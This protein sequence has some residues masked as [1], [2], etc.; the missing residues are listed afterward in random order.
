MANWLDTALYPFDRAVLGA[1]HSFA[2]ASGGIL[3]WLMKLLGLVGEGGAC[4]IL[5]GLILCL[6]KKTRKQGVCVLFALACGAIITNICL[7]NIVARPRPFADT[8]KPFYDWWVYIGS[9]H[10]SKNSFPSGH[11]TA[12]MASMLGAFLCSKKRKFAWGYF[13]IALLMGFSR[14]YLVVHYATDVLAGLLAGALGGLSAF[15]LVRW[16]FSA[17]EQNRHKRAIAAFLDFDLPRLFSK[18]KEGGNAPQ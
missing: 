8:L 14:M 9:P 11:T 4:F 3:D 10:A 17:L 12:A 7:K 15:F 5:F 13:A 16:L 1:I 6:F 18:K 2:V